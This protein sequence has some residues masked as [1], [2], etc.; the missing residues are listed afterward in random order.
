MRSR[1]A[2]SSPTRLIASAKA[3]RERCR[4]RRV[5]RP[6]A[7]PRIDQEPGLLGDHDLRDPAHRGRHD[8]RLAGHRLEVD[9]PERLVDR[10]AAE[11][12]GVRVELDR[13]LPGEHLADPDHVRPAHAHLG[14]PLGHLGPDLGRVGGAGAEHDLER[15]VD[16]GDRVDQVDDPLL[17][18]DPADEQHE[19]TVGIDAVLLEER[20]ARVR[21]VLV[22]VDPVVDHVDPVGVHREEA[23]DVR[24]RLPGHRDQRVRVEDRRPLHPARQVVGAAELLHLPRAQ[25]LQ[26]VRRHHQRHA[27]QLLGQEPGHVRVPRVAVDDVGVERV[28]GHREVAL[29]RRRARP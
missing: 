23:Q 6:L 9:D 12:R 14:D 4:V 15:G 24:P 28:L 27:P 16:V 22:E 18:G 26:R 13:G 20:R 3:G 7:D 25:R 19:R 1:S 2:S 29:R 10:R 17:A 11:H 21:A 5:E 8:R